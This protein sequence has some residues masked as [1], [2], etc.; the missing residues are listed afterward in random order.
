MN[1]MV[2]YIII[3]I[4]KLAGRGKRTWNAELTPIGYVTWSKCWLI[5]KP[6]ASCLSP[7]HP[8]GRQC[9]LWGQVRGLHGGWC[10]PHP[11]LWRDLP[12]PSEPEK[13]EG[14][15]NS[16]LSTGWICSGSRSQFP[17]SSRLFLA[18][19]CLWVGR[20]KRN[21]AY[22]PLIDFQGC[23]RR[24]G[25]GGGRSCWWLSLAFT[26]A[27]LTLLSSLWISCVHP[28]LSTCCV[29]LF[30]SLPADFGS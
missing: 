26:S 3:S 1:G 22:I 11:C 25:E 21:E 8:P 13:S 17:F 6:I 19:I 15:G 20:W 10:A 14:Q 9:S 4:P 24:S 5:A 12:V 27:A 28:P 29:C 18:T 7:L 30:A 16:P 23:D 2:S